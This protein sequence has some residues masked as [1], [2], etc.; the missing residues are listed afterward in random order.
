MMNTPDIA[1]IWEYFASK[2]MLTRCLVVGFCVLVCLAQI[3]PADLVHKPVLGFLGGQVILWFFISLIAVFTISEVQAKTGRHGFP[4]RM[5]LYPVKT[6]QLVSLPMVFG[7]LCC[8]LVWLAMT[9]LVFEPLGVNAPAA[10]GAAIIIAILT[11]FQAMSWWP[12]RS[13]LT[14][15]FMM[16]VST[17]ILVLMA[18]WP[19]M[20]WEWGSTP[21][22]IEVA[23]MIPLSCFLAYRGVSR[24]RCDEVNRF[25]DPTDYRDK[26]ERLSA[27]LTI[28]PKE[29]TSAIRAQFWLEWRC[30]GA[31]LVMS[32]LLLCSLA[33]VAL[34]ISKFSSGNPVVALRLYLF[35]MFFVPLYL[36]MVLGMSYAPD[37]AKNNKIVISPFLLTRPIDTGTMATIK[38]CSAGLSLVL[39]EIL[40]VSMMALAILATGYLGALDTM[41]KP[42]VDAIGMP[43]FLIGTSLSILL[44]TAYTWKIMVGAMLPSMTGRTWVVAIT[45]TSI[46]VIVLLSVIGFA[47]MMDDH[48]LIE[49]R[50][51]SWFLDLPLV[52]V[53]LLVFKIVIGYT[54]F[55]QILRTRQATPKLL[56]IALSIWAAL[57]GLVLITGWTLF[58]PESILDWLTLLLVAVLIPPFGRFALAPLALDWHRHQ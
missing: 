58:R 31:G 28:E 17:A 56:R 36:A 21:I 48:Y 24:D 33:T 49:S 57:A 23:I 27:S 8:G 14:R 6:S 38:L 1:L 10:L 26:Y 19:G 35:C 52:G 46:I 53:A 44:I 15:T 20:V 16:T 41:I 5:F 29:F 32:V 34:V 37:H 51:Q 54:A 3:I 13:V 45:S 43:R 25:S 40:A 7:S 30:K 55:R 22:W 4:S 12:F 47:A 50:F 39:S 9:V 18:I 42:V 11:W 2:R